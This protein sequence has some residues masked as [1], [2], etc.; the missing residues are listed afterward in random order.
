VYGQFHKVFFSKLK[1]RAGHFSDSHGHRS[2][3]TAGLRL[4]VTDDIRSKA[5]VDR[6]DQPASESESPA[7]PRCAAKQSS[8][9]GLPG[10]FVI[11]SFRWLCSNQISRFN[12]IPSEKGR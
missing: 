9:A 2:V 5:F 11:Q 8:G 10:R 3:S 7:S 1:W 6:N 12:F 4:A